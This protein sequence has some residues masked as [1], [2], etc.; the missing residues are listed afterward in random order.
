V[1]DPAELGGEP[2]AIPNL[3]GFPIAVVSS[4]ASPLIHYDD[5]IV[6]FLKAAGCDVDLV[7]FADYG[8]HGNGHAMMFERNHREAL[9]V[10]LDWIERRVT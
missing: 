2:R 10:L 8:V 9:Q 4:E 6:G 3:Q 7:R 1:S 5:Q